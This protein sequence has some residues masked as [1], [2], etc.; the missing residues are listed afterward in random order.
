MLNT[1]FAAIIGL[2]SIYAVLKLSFGVAF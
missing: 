1:F 2:A